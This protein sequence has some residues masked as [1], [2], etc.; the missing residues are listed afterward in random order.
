MAQLFRALPTGMCRTDHTVWSKH[1]SS[2]HIYVFSCRTWR[3]AE[4]SR[5]EY[6]GECR[7]GELVPGEV[8]VLP[9]QALPLSLQYPGRGDG[10]QPHAVANQQDDTACTTGA[11]VHTAWYTPLQRRPRVLV[12][13]VTTWNQQTAAD[14]ISEVKDG[15]SQIYC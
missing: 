4:L 15:R 2:L 6:L 7:G 13:V 12:P 3:Q 10:R 8:A 9:W 5:C 14:W 1:L 11:G